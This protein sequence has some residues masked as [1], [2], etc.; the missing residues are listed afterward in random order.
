MLVTVTN[1]TVLMADYPT[2]DLILLCDYSDLAGVTVRFPS[3]PS[4]SLEYSLRAAIE[5]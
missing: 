2:V 4:S 5:Q 1:K 3:L